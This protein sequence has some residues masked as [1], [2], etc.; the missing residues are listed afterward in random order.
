[1]T[2]VLHQCQSYQVEAYGIYFFYMCSQGREDWDKLEDNEGSQ[3][4]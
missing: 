4:V 1:M 3:G 2:V